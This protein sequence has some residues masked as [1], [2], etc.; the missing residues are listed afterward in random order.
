[1]G[2]TGTDLI[3]YKSLV[4]DDTDANG[5]AIDTTAVVT[6][7]SD[8]NL[9]PDVTSDEATTG[10][11][12]YRKCFRKNTNATSTWL[13]PVTWIVQQ[14]T[15]CTLYMGVGINHADDTRGALSELG[16]WS[17]S[18]VVAA[19]SSG[20]DSRTLTIYGE[21]SASVYATENVVLNGTVEVLSTTIFSRVYCVFVSAMSGTN[22]ITIKEGS[23][24]TSRGT[25]GINGKL[26]TQFVTWN[27]KSLGIQHGDIV[28]GNL[29]GL[30]YKLVVPPGA[31]YVS[32]NVYTTKT[33]GETS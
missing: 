28:A 12:R 17:G 1:M 29:L 9:F 25:I 7:G 6:S 22:T 5:G 15:N 3:E 26:C 32:G 31:G 18:A 24:G 23:G 8:N 4:V 14:P 10:I 33:E 21:D 19:V 20:S 27:M 13:I 11:T 30:W 2:V 16:S